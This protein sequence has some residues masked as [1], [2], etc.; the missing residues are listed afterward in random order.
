MHE[1][2]A[3]QGN[4]FGQKL[5]SYIFHS[6]CSYLEVSTSG[7][8]KR[9]NCT[10]LCVEFTPVCFPPKA[11]KSTDGFSDLSGQ[12]LPLQ[13]LRIWKSSFWIWVSW[14]SGCSA[15][16]APLLGKGT[17]TD[18]HGDVPFGAQGIHHPH[19]LP[20][21]HLVESMVFLESKESH[22]SRGHTIITRQG[23]RINVA[24]NFASNTE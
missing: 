8:G 6:N 14:L 10:F 1:I 23:Y 22:N 15:I 24:F 12:V 9:H 19:A 13:I 17:I 18:G 11:L 2:L 3:R 7:H 5:S 21:R 20:N 4:L 16:P